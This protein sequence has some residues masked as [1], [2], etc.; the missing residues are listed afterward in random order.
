MNTLPADVRYSHL[1]WNCP[2]STSTADDLIQKLQLG[3]ES[4]LVDIGCGWG[5]LLLQ[6]A[7]HSGAAA[8]GVDTDA[9]L[10]ARCKVAAY[11]K[12]MEIELVNMPGRDWKEVRD[13]AIC[14]GSSHAFGGTREMLEGLAAVVP[15]GRV[16]VGDMCWEEEDKELSEECRAMFGDDVVPLSRFVALCRETGWKLMHLETATRRDWDTFE[17]GHR[18]GPREWLLNNANDK[19][20]SD[21]EEGLAKREDDYFRIYRGHLGFVFAILA[22]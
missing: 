12:D 16:L 9:D 11:K 20:A 13:R 2:L 1:R 6:A 3:A 21:V 4:T 22:R 14:I 7:K 5:E 10:L 18:A 17:C 8:V 15:C 19:R